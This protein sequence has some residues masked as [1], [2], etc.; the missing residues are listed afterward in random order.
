MKEKISMTMTSHSKKPSTILKQADN[1]LSLRGREYGSYIDLFD[2]MSERF[3]QSHGEK[4][5]PYQCAML[6][7]ELKLARLDLNKYDEDSLIDAINYLALAGALA[8]D[9][10]EKTVGDIDWKDLLNKPPQK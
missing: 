1:L 6:M 9:K 8:T 10:A 5:T 7:V 3:T 2:R 4:H